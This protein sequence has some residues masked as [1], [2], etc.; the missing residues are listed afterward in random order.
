MDDVRRCVACGSERWNAAETWGVYQLATCRACGVTFTTNP[1]YRRT[2]YIAAYDGDPADLPVPQHHV[3]VYSGPELRLKYEALAF[4]Q[5]LPP[6]RLTPAERH[7]LEW[8]GRHAPK[9]A[10]I[11][12]CGC[13]TGRFLDTLS[14]A[15]FEAVGVELSATLVGLLQ[16]RGLRA[17]VGAAPEFPWDGLDPF[18]IV[19][20]EVLEH[21]PDPGTVIAPLMA[22]FPAAHVLASVPSALRASRGRG[23]THTPSDYPPNH[24]IRWTELGLERFFTRMG[25]T[26]VSLFSPPPVG[27]EMLP[28]MAQLLL[29]GRGTRRWGTRPGHEAVAG[30]VRVTSGTRVAATGALWLLRALQ[31][32]TDIVGRPLA[33]R[34]QRSG[35]SAGSFLVVATP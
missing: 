32:A 1:D 17:V 33:A 8:L 16:R 12:D 31:A 14:R 4:P 22:R 9:H 5:L 27:S 7:A 19:F 30:T 11:I 29:G 15:G 10:R 18:A 20:F 6:P 2:R 25:Y 28:G 23:G 24:F 13:G 26:N 35:A 3:H 34:A 21:L